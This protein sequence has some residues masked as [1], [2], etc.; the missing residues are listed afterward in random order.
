MSKSL[1]EQ[2][3]IL[4]LEFTVRRVEADSAEGGAL[5]S[6]YNITKVPT[7]LLSKEAGR[8]PGM[9]QAWNGSGTVEPDG[10]LVLREAYPPYFDLSNGTLAG[11]VT[12]ITLAYEPCE[13]CYDANRV[14]LLL[15]TQYGVSVFN[16]ENYSF[17]TTEWNSTVAKYN[18]T[19]VPA[20]I[21]SPELVAYPGVDEI[22]LA[23]LGSREPDGWY[24]YR[25]MNMGGITYYDLLMN[26]TVS[27]ID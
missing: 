1:I 10:V 24:V 20:A 6:Q 18:I 11:N 17:N 22:W 7:I 2:S 26:S 19:R 15:E 13:L 25:G 12:V 23:G 14:R 27:R 16:S 8:S 4:G 5:I 9:L 3:A 21:I